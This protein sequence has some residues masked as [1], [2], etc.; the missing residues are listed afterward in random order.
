MNNHGLKL[1]FSFN[2]MTAGRVSD[3]RPHLNLTQMPLAWPSVDQRDFLLFFFACSSV[4]GYVAFVL[5]FMCS[6]SLLL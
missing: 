2:C 1:H 4:V 3:W 5:V 6:S